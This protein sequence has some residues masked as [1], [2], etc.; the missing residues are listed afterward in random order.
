MYKNLTISIVTANFNNAPYLDD[1]FK[2]IKESSLLPS[3][4][5]IVDDASTDNSIK[6]I[7]K[8]EKLSPC[9]FT[10]IELKRNIGFANAINLAIEKSKG[11][12]VLRIDP[13][14]FLHQKRIELEYNYL[15]TNPQ[16]DIIGSNTSY[17][18]N[19]LKKVVGRSSF[20]TSTQK[21]NKGIQKG[22]ITLSNGSFTSKKE[23]FKQNKYKQEFFGFE[24]YVLFAEM[25]KNGV[26]IKNLH[27]SLTYYRVGNQNRNIHHMLRVQKGIS[28]QRGK[29]FGKGNNLIV[30]YTRAISAYLYWC[31]LRATSKIG[32]IFFI[33]LT[34]PFKINRISRL[35]ER[36]TGQ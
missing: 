12:L 28:N 1:F 36:F 30:I 10:V 3:E 33:S 19:S 24:E 23:V 20:P 26:I 22:I 17:Y 34:I 25:V 13:D 14:D 7:S 31:A 9:P 27:Q 8:W 6:I 18:N 16:I 5:V 2:S 4:V 35:R 32:F 11:D 15:C 29:I 21:I